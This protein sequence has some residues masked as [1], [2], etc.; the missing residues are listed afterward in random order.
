MTFTDA[1]NYVCKM[2]QPPFDDADTDYDFVRMWERRHYFIAVIFFVFS[3]V[4]V[5]FGIEGSSDAVS[6]LLPLGFAVD[7][8]YR[9]RR[10]REIR[11]WFEVHA[12]QNFDELQRISQH[13]PST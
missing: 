3:G 12:P 11:R 9:C 4:L 13:E 2:R 1:Q 5:S 10:F 8:A 7:Q 6:L